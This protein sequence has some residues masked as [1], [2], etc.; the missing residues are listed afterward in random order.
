MMILH[1]GNAALFLKK[2]RDIATGGYES[3]ALLLWCHYSFHLRVEKI[4]ERLNNN[5]FS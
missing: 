1:Y 2:P 5:G 4:E 3:Y